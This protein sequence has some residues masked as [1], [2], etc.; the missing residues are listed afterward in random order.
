MLDH[1]LETF[2]PCNGQRRPIESVDGLHL[3]P[4]GVVDFVHAARVWD[5]PEIVAHQ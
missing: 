4:Q 2:H 1:P 3:A 5:G